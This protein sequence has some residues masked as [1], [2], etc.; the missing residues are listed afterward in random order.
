MQKET[1]EDVQRRV[2]AVQVKVKRY[3]R[4]PWTIYQKPFRITENL[5]FVG[6]QYVSSYLIDTGEGLVLIDC[7]FAETF[8]QVVNNIYEIGFSPKEIRYLFL[9]HGHFDH[10]GAAGLLQQMSGASVYI[11][12]GDHFFFTERR[13]LIHYVDHVF[14]FSIAG[15][16]PYDEPWTIGNTTFRFVHTPGHTPGCTTILFNSTVNGRAVTCAMHGGLGVNGLTFDELDRANLPR[17]LKQAFYD[18]LC[19]CE[20][21]EVD[22]TCPSHNH[23]CD[24][25]SRALRDDGSGE[26]FCD[27]DAWSAMLQATKEK[28]HALP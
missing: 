20:K 22:I 8:Y 16:Y 13:D 10:C 24:I 19:L 26:A 1:K 23:N 9:S 2:D 18:Q 28:F 7:G 25:L 27:P 15:S 14:D 21:F 6:T 12:Q 3:M 4:E 5:Y 17:M 11:G